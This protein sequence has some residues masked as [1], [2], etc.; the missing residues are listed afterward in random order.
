M[1]WLNDAKAS[2]TVI[3]SNIGTRTLESMPLWRVYNSEFS[4]D[5]FNRTNRGW[6]RFSPLVLSNGSLVPTIYLGSTLEVAFMEIVFRDV[7]LAPESSVGFLLTVEESR[8]KRRIACLKP[9]ADLLIADLS[10]IGMRRLGLG[11]QDVIDCDQAGYPITQKLAAWLYENHPDIQGIGWTSRQNDKGQAYILFEP[12]MRGIS[13]DV[14]GSDEKFTEGSH[15]ESL[16]LLADA[17]GVS[18]R[19]LP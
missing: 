13:L 4:A 9:S 11:R 12:R 17:L 6:A 15:K 8:E 16:S 2:C 1:S 14:A 7:P 5:S 3:A 10:T 18:V 19:F